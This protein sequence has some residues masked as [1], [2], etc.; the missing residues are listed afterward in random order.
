MSG[1]RDGAILLLPGTALHCT[2]TVASVATMVPALVSLGPS[3]IDAPLDSKVSFTKHL[4][5]TL[6]QSRSIV[7]GHR[8]DRGILT[9]PQVPVENV[10]PPLGS[11]SF[12]PS[13]IAEVL[14]ALCCAFCSLSPLLPCWVLTWFLRGLACR[15]SVHWPF[16]FLSMGVVHVSSSR[17]SS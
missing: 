16:C 10:N 5:S 14:L 6:P 9:F 7:R 2:A 15:V 17:L 13:H 3:L 12:L 8:G 4:G 11:H 1:K